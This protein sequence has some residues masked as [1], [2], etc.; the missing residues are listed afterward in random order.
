MLAAG[1]RVVASARDRPADLDDLVKQH[2]DRVKTV[3]LDVTQPE[4]AASAVKEAVDAFGRIDVLVNNAGYANVDSAS[5]TIALDDFRAQIDD[6][7]LRRRTCHA[8]GAAR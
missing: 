5:R 2:G 4:Q 3:A 8:R 7:F 6:Q 1:H